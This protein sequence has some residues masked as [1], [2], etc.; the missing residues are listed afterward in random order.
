VQTGNKEEIRRLLA[1]HIDRTRQ[2]YTNAN[3]LNHTGTAR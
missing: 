3:K 2:V 1:D